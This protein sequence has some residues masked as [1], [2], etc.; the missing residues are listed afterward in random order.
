MYS[1]VPIYTHTNKISNENKSLSNYLLSLPYYGSQY[2]NYVKFKV[3]YKHL[4][5]NFTEHVNLRNY[6]VYLNWTV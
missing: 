1:Y 5:I 3:F 6:L 4:L 2:I